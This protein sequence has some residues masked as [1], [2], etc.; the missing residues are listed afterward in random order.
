MKSGNSKFYLLV[1]IAAVVGA[2]FFGVGRWGGAKNEECVFCKKKVVEKQKFYEDELVLGIVS[3]KPIVSGHVLVVT[4]RHVEHFEQL[5]PEEITSIGEA[6]KKIHSAASQAYAASGYLLLQK[7]GIQAGQT[8]PH[9]HVHYIPRKSKETPGLGF[10]L[11][12]F[13]IPLMPAVS[14]AKMHDTVVKMQQ[15]I[16]LSGTA[17]CEP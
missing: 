14:E 7:N 3:H 11:R 4:K 1:G 8:V 10:L 9:M 6:V 12:F 2:L 17:A 16:S 13:F 15:Q 5:T